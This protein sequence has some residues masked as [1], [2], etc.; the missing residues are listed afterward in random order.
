MHKPDGPALQDSDLAGRR[1]FRG[2]RRQD[3]I[4][5]KAHAHQPLLRVH[6]PDWNGFIVLTPS[7]TV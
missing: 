2:H 4:S 1:S 7:G 3:R 6:Q 5:E